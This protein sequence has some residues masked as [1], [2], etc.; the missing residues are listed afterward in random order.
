MGFASSCIPGAI[1]SE[2]SVVI[3]ARA[4]VLDAS[5]FETLIFR[6]RP[7]RCLCLIL[8]R[9]LV[10]IWTRH[11]TQALIVDEMSNYAV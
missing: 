11:V 9:W 7:I 10:I 5:S 3:L 2:L 8:D 1:L 6:D 4:G